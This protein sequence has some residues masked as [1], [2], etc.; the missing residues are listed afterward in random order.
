M[1]ATG[2]KDAYGLPYI[3]DPSKP[4]TL[5]QYYFAYWSNPVL[6]FIIIGLFGLTADAR[7]A[8]WSGICTMANWV[9]W[10]LTSRG[11]GLSSPLDTMVFGDYGVQT[12]ETMSHDVEKG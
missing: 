10:R 4:F 8:Y 9:G 2:V 11:A 12:Q 6:A 3:D 7:E 5:A 1:H